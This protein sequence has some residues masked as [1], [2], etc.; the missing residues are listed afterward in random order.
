MNS[1]IDDDCGLRQ[2]FD[3]VELPAFMEWGEGY[4][5]GWKPGEPTG[6]YALD[7]M[8]GELYADIAVKHARQIKDP[9]FV[10]LVLATIYFKATRRLIEMGGREQGFLDRLARLAY[11]GSLN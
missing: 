8:T 9:A 7:F 3:V 10:G 11:A 4:I 5:D 6:D 2:P 1:T